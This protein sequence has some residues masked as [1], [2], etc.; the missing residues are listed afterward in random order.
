MELAICDWLAIALREF[1]DQHT[2]DVVL[3]VRLGCLII[4][5]KRDDVEEVILAELLEAICELLHVNVLVSSRLLLAR[6]LATDAVRVGS[7]RLCQERD[8]LWLRVAEGLE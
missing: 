3:S 6:I 2:L 5:N 1:V 4:V 8:E 7:A